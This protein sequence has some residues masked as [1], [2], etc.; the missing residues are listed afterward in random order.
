MLHGKYEQMLNSDRTKRIVSVILI[1]I[2]PEGEALSASQ[3]GVEGWR[4]M[5]VLADLGSPEHDRGLYMQN[6]T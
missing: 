6:F 3:R 2:V 1:L 4:R 5:D